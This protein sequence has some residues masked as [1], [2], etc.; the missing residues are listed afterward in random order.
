MLPALLLPPLPPAEGE[1]KEGEEEEI[2][3]SDDYFSP[4]PPRLELRRDTRA[5]FE[6][7]QI[8][9]FINNP[10][11]SESPSATSTE[12]FFGFATA[13][14]TG[15]SGNITTITGTRGSHA[16]TVALGI[17]LGVSIGLLSLVA[18]VWLGVWFLRERKKEKAAATAGQVQYPTATTAGAGAPDGG[19]TG[20]PGMTQVQQQGGGVAGAAGGYK[21]PYTTTPAEL[22]QNAQYSGHEMATHGGNTAEMAAP[23]QSH[24]IGHQQQQQVGYSNS[25]TPVQ[26]GGFNPTYHP[27]QQQQ[28]YHEVP[29]QH[30]GPAAPA[31]QHHV[32]EVPGRSATPNLYE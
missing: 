31:T 15:S 1:G 19:G 8:A 25:T 27:Q 11:T 32:A 30:A 21:Q 5:Y 16:T 9:S 10:T 2:L 6:E 20:Q 24:G 29:G 26:Q 3:K 12:G 28:V 13:T 4:S 18:F 17:G 14:S 23:M 22:S 7:R